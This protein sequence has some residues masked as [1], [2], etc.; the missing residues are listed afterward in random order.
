MRTLY[1]FAPNTLQLPNEQAHKSFTLVPIED[2]TPFI[3]GMF[4]PTSRSLVLLSTRQR[5]HFDMMT[6]FDSK[7][8]PKLINGQKGDNGMPMYAKKLQEFTTNHEVTIDNPDSIKKFVKAYSDLSEADEA[9]LEELFTL[10][11][12]EKQMGPSLQVAESKEAQS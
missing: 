9:Y 8:Y 12:Q 11:E 5:Q 1:F 10:P 3:Q 4:D 6:Q 7:G 2:N